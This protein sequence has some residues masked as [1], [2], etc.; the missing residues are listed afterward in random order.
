MGVGQRLEIRHSQSLVMTPQLQQ[1]IKLLQLSN[2]ELADYC[3]GELERNPLLERDESAPKDGER[4]T[5]PPEQKASER[6][7]ESLAREDFSKVEDLDTSAH[8]N[9]YDGESAAAPAPSQPLADWS[10]V[11]GG[12]HFE[13]DED[14]LESAVAGGGS[15]KDHLEQQLAIA[16]LSGEE[17]LDCLALIDSIDEGGYLRADLADLAGRLGS[18][19]A[20]VNRVLTVLQGFEPVGIGARDL[21][22][23]LML[24]LKARDRYDPAMAALLAR[25]D[26]VAR[27]DMAQLIQ[28]CGVD[29]EDVAEMIAEIRALNPRPGLSFGAE[30]VQPVV[31][32]I[33]VRVGPDGGWLVELNSDTLPRLLVN[34]RYYAQVAKGARDRDSRNYLTECL[35][36]A[37]W[38]VKSLDQRARTILKVASEIVRHQDA[39]LT[40]G[41]RHLRPLNLR[42]IA[43]AISMHESTVSRVTS[44][45][46]IATPRG[47]FELKYF[48][49]ASIQSVNGTESHSAEAVRDRIREM[50]ENEEPRE[51]LSDDRIVALLTA[52]GVNI[53]RRTVAKYREA[54]RIPSSV[55]RRRLK[56]G[57]ALAR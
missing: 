55:E 25:L 33:F 53:A 52:D 5:A 20:T 14:L 28:V 30:P 6:A 35:N 45:K 15:L 16:A 47:L 13:G 44:N 18:D 38:L 17:R 48:F 12:S 7:D 36:N 43:E 9:L 40:H 22:E 31:P 54:L 51:I 57:E 26:L 39:F 37:N 3:E 4:E 32:D 49:T 23:C 8:E 1:A 2:L 19:L 41:V 50:I 24:Q 56:A 10:G 29:G 42:I 11:R 34:A 27:R 21:A 46:Y